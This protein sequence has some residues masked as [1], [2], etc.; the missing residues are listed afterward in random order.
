MIVNAYAIL[1]GFL[2]ALRLG[3]GL[4]AVC[5]AI[6]AWRANHRAAK[7]CSER[8]AER[9]TLLALTACVL[10]GLSVVS[11]PVL[12]LLLQSYVPAWEGVMCIY[13]VTQIGTG[14]LGAARFLPWLLS[15]MQL[16]K[17]AL[18]FA[19]GAWLVLHLLNGRT[20]SGPLVGRTLL[21]LLV[22]GIV[23]TAD[24]SAEISYL[25][26][27]KKEEPN[28]AGCC[29][30]AFDSAAEA[31][32]FV[33]GTWVDDRH[34]PWLFGAYY[35][36]NGGTALAL[37]GALRLGWTEKWLGLL[38]VLLPLSIG[39][40]ALF[41]ID[42]AAPML[43]RLPYHHCPYDLLPRVPESMVAVGLFVL[44]A[45]A[46]GWA[47]V[48]GGLGRHPETAAL[49]PS[50]VMKLLHLGLFGYLGSLVMMSLELALSCTAL[51]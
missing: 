24:A 26:I 45:F 22:L 6:T 4:L 25:V 39:L 23:A 42:A 48:A 1:D 35:G 9:S 27:P 20:A 3:F 40:N 7:D 30:Q 2:S 17:P 41:L 16:L 8:L 15:A 11:W 47:C 10:T 36:L 18:V 12:Y 43:L 13:G 34:R 19:G 50:L 5:L 38:A 14:S 28:L 51:R 33:P 46:V 21:L 44:G 49:L 31:S 37:F 32:R 29:T